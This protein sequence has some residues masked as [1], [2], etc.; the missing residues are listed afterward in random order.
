LGTRKNSIQALIAR[1][2]T[3]LA[4]IEGAYEDSLHR[5]QIHADLKVDIK[6]LCGNLRSILDYIAHD[7]RET[8]CAT[9]NPKARFY[10]PIFV[11]AAEFEVM[12]NKWYTGLKNTLPEL[13]S[14][15]EAVQPYHSDWS[16]LGIFNR[17]NNDN[18]HGNLVAQTRNE[19]EQ[20]KVSAGRGGVSWLPTAVRFGRGVFING[21]PIDPR[22]QMPVPDPSLKVERIIWVDFR[23]DGENVSALGLLKQA[24]AG[25]RKIAS[26]IEKWV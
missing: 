17:I 6:N 5:Q 22:T 7:I 14:F 23:F 25:I 16:W 26:D 18:K 12:A 8:H 1:C 19:T 3:D 4:K 10:F 9:A 15:L 2:E 21:V 11:S 24:L 20:V 13:W